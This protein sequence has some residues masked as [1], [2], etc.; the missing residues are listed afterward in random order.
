MS[1]RDWFALA[2][3][4]LGCN[5]A[6]DQPDRAPP[7]PAPPL[8]SSA[9]AASALPPVIASA[10]A[11]GSAPAPIA[12]ELA[13]RW[14][15]RY[16]AKKGSVELP[17]KLKAKAFGSDDGKVAIG[18]GSIDLAILAN[19][20]IRGKMSGALGAAAI[21]G[22]VDGEVIRAVVQPDD[23]SAANAMT[24]ILVGGRKGETIACELHVA[25]PDGTVI[26]ESTVELT[27]KK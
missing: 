12:G 4:L 13:G 22:K 7:A 16:E 21:S 15:G 2:A 8:H 11:G 9:A 24:G 3:V 10:S 19:G 6:P 17:S 27:R 26:R 18:N 1:Q 14:E 25:G 23:P 20:D 5:S